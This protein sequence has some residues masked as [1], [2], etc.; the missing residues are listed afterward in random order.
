MYCTCLL[1]KCTC[2]T[3]SCTLHMIYTTYMYMYMKYDV[4]MHVCAWMLFCHRFVVFC[5]GRAGGVFVLKIFVLIVFW[6]LFRIRR[7]PGMKETQLTA[8]VELLPSSVTESSKSKQ[9][10]RPPISMNFEVSRWDMYD[11]GVW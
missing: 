3:H 5:F 6:W 11:V 2:E 4:H 9:Q 1:I 7:F 10:T 8:D